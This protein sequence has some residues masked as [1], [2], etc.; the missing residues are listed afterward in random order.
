[1]QAFNAARTD[2]TGDEL[3]LLQHPPVFTQG[4]AGRREH[5]LDPGDIPVVKT[6]RG[7]QVTYHGPGQLV[8]YALLDLRRGAHRREGAGPPPR[9][10][11]PRRARCLRL[12]AASGARACP[13]STST[14]RRSPPLGLR[15]ARGCSYHGLALNVDVDLAPFRAHRPVRLPGPRRRRALPTTASVKH[16]CGAAKAGRLA[17]C[18]PSPDARNERPQ[19]QQKRRQDRAHPDQDRAGRAAAQARLDPRQGRHG[20]RFTEVKR[21]LREHKPA[22]GVRGSLLP[23]H[24]RMLRQGHGHLHDPGRPVHAPLPVLRRRPTAGRCRPIADEPRHLARDHRAQ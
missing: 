4:L 20:Q 17:S 21:M 13:A 22:H 3:W 11:R 6:D 8:A 9:A 19:A 5:L 24:R 14:T 18:A 23:Q 15:I 10:G 2:D 1:M 7:G 12:A 16:R